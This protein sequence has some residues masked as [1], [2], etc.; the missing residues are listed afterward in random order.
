MATLADITKKSRSLADTISR[1][2]AS[3]APRK[4][5]NLQRA[6]IRAND[7]NTMF[8]VQGGSSR[9]IGVK[10]LTFTYNYAPD[11]APYGKWWNDPSVSETVRKGKTKNVPDAINFADKGL[12]DPKVIRAIDELVDL[13]GESVLFKIDEELKSVEAE[14]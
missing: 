1:S 7:V 10:S 5:G 11:D 8:E 3:R 13:I 9:G 6:L 12:N 4:T 14:Y 2:V